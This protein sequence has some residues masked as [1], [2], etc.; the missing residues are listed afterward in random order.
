MHLLR[1]EHMNSLLSLLQQAGYT[2]IGPRLSNGVVVPEQ[3]TCA[4]DMPRGVK[5]VQHAGSYRIEHGDDGAYF[6]YAVGP[7]SWKRFL[8]PPEN[9]LWHARRTAHGFEL[10]HDESETPSYA[11]IGVRA[12]DLHAMAIQDRVFAGGDFAD[13]D[14]RARRERSFVVAV[15]C[16]APADTCFCTTMGTGPDAREGFDLVLTELAADGH[17]FLVE[18]GSVRGNSVLGHLPVEKATPDRIT[19]A[20]ALLRQAGDRMRQ[21]FDASEVRDGLAASHEHPHWQKVAERCLACAN[22]TMACPTCFCS[23]GFEKAHVDGE[24]SERWRSWDSCFSNGFAYMHGG[25]VRPS[26]RA[27]YRH[28]LIHKLSAWHQQFGTQGCVGCGRCVTWCPAAID[29]V[30]EA[31]AIVYGAGG[32]DEGD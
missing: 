6:G 16:T 28:W 25:S 14:Y 10:V 19:Q 17:A 3:V 2:T 8:Y 23:R 4:D 30:E 7:S 5:D 13:G 9:R 12:C 1:A 18:A 27:R 15:N 24:S 31:R 11:F 32:H 21:R 26:I 22:C 20:Q 29:L